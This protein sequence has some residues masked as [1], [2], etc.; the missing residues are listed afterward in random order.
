[1]F[2]KAN[3]FQLLLLLSL[4][5]RGGLKSPDRQS[6]TRKIIHDRLYAGLIFA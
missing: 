5:C 2:C 4:P 1:M 3:I 6:W